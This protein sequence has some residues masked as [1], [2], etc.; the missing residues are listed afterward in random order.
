METDNKQDKMFLFI[1]VFF[2]AAMSLSTVI[3]IVFFLLNL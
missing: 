2:V 3:L 1:G